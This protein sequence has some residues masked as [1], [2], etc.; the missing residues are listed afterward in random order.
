MLNLVRIIQKNLKHS[1]ITPERKTMGKPISEHQAVAF[2]LADMAT[3]VSAARA[4]YVEAARLKDAGLP[5]ATA[6]ITY[7]K[8]D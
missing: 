2:M 1:C 6:H 8:A 4:L 7:R 5:F 3:A